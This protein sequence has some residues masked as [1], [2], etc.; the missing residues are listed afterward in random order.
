MG[1]RGLVT[2]MLGQVIHEGR[3]DVIY[4]CGPM[5]MLRQVTALAGRYDIPVQVLVEESMACGIGV[6]MTCVLPV[7]GRGRGDPDGPV[8]RGRAG[9]PRR[10]GALGRRGHDPVR[11]A[12]R[13]GLE[14]APPPEPRPRPPGQRDGRAAPWPID[15]RTRLG[16]VELPN[17]ILTASG[18]A[19]VGPRAGPVLRRGQDRRGRHQVGHAGPAR[20]A[21]DPADGR[22][23]ERHAQLDRPA[24]PRHRRV[25]AARPALAAVPRGAGRGVDRGRHRRTSTPNWPAGC[26]TRPG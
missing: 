7:V 20:G 14:A 4:A 1:V 22:D 23:A 16:H 6:C 26:P 25:P 24:G 17:P 11:R 18:C 19:G 2:D 13:A 10:P 9:V 21:P 12:R 3:T 5:G 8:L 15:L